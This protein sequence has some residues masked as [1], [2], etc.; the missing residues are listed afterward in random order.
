MHY[1]AIGAYGVTAD[2]LKNVA[3]PGEITQNI[4][5]EVGYAGGIVLCASD[6]ETVATS[7]TE[8]FLGEVAKHRAWERDVSRVAA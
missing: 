7:F 8:A 5:N 4:T 2:W 6:L 3:L 1:R